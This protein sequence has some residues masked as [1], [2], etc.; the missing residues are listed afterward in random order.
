MLYVNKI[1]SDREKAPTQQQKSELIAD[2]TGL[3]V[4]VLNKNAV[5]TVVVI[6]ELPTDN[7]VLT[8]K[9]PLTG[10]ITAISG[11]RLKGISL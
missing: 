8:E 5:S 2:A 7:Q 1:V 3:L 6:E 10:G 9:L 11:P 4:R